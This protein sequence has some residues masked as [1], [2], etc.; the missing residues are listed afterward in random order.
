MGAWVWGSRG[1]GGGVVC[2]VVLTKVCYI[3]LGAALFCFVGLICT[4]L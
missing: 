2:I 1:G 4:V 3:N